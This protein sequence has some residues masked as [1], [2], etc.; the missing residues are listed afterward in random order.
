MHCL[1]SSLVKITKEIVQDPFGNYAIQHCLEAWPYEP[2]GKKYC[3]EIMKIL[4]AHWAQYASSKYSSNVMEKC[5]EVY[6]VE[7]SNS[8]WSK[9]SQDED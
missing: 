1:G 5:L 6:P 3:S 2:I 4:M 8:I 7:A 9:I